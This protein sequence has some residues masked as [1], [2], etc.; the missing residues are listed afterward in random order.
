MKTIEEK[1]K[2]IAAFEGY[3]VDYGF[4]KKGVL[5]AGH[6]IRL[7]QL[8]YHESWDWLMPVVDKIESSVFPIG[9]SKF[10]DEGIHV[11]VQM[12]SGV[13]EITDEDRNGT[14]EINVFANSKLDATYQAVIQFIEWYNSI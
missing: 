8:R 7:N 4:D 3:K 12:I 14:L 9:T 6:H 10:G 5:F 2:M 1:N 11:D 13:C